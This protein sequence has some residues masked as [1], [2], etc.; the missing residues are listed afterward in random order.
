[1]PRS[2]STQR[3]AGMSSFEPS[4]IPAWLA[5]VCEERS[6]S[7]STK[8]CDPSASQ[9]AIVGALPSRI[10]RWSTG[11]ARP[12][13]SRYTMP[14]T[15][16]SMRSPERRAIRWITR[17]M[18]ASSSFV[19]ATT[20]STVAIAEMTSAA[21]IP[22]PNLPTSTAPSVNAS[23]TRSTTAL[24]RRSRRNDVATVYGRRSA[25]TI[26]ARTA[27]SAAIRSAAS[28]ASQKSPTSK[29]G[30]IAAARKTL[31]ALTKS[32]RSNLAGRS[33]GLTSVRR[34][35]LPYVEAPSSGSDMGGP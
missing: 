11:F 18:Y 29:P 16:V 20:S 30:R 28:S 17:I 7:H 32:A 5:P 24:S 23:T 14:G 12:S 25:A 31:A 4:R 15:S 2:F 6:V 13:I 8:R 35:R 34:G 21:R 9:R 27:L 22:D 19:P 33:G 1:M 26:G 10:A 3:K